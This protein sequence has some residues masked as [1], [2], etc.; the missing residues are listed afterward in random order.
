MVTMPKDMRSHGIIG[1]VSDI[2]TAR[3]GCDEVE[4]V[5]LRKIEP[6]LRQS[7]AR[8]LLPGYN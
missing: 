5:A 7:G 6:R 8:T 4:A 1:G 2:D 3:S